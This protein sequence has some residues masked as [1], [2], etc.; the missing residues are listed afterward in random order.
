MEA[1]NQK[2]QRWRRR[3]QAAEAVAETGG[4]GGARVEYAFGRRR[5]VRGQAGCERSERGKR[6]KREGCRGG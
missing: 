4:G 6:V 3:Q 2:R 1:G 5:Y